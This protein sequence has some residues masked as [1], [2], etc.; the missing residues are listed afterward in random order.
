MMVEFSAMAHADAGTRIG[1]ADM[2]IGTHTVVTHAGASANWTD[3]RPGADTIAADMRT[4][5]Y[6]QNINTY[7]SAIGEGGA[8]CKQGYCKNC[9]R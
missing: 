6:T 7:A 1:R 3:M 5:T 9:N 4:N 8:S 2:G